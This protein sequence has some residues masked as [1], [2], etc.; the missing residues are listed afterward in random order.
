M[1]TQA[2][3]TLSYVCDTAHH[4]PDRPLNLWGLLKSEISSSLFLQVGGRQRVKMAVVQVGAH[5]HSIV[6][7]HRCLLASLCHRCASKHTCCISQSR[8][9]RPTESHGV[10]TLELSFGAPILPALPL[11]PG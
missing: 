8:A 3:Q 11:S 4:H 6:V 5:A 10:K 2:Y 9:P 1:T 7:G